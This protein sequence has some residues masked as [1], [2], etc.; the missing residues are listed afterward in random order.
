MNVPRTFCW[1]YRGVKRPGYVWSLTIV[2]TL[3]S[4]CVG[5]QD[6][7]FGVGSYGQTRNYRTPTRR[8]SDR[9]IHWRL[10]DRIDPV[11]SAPGS[12]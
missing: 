6:E 12:S 10:T 3:L 4:I 7:V 9:V 2:D 1:N 8:G 11:A 5:L